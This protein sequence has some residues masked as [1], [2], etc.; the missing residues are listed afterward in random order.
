MDMRRVGE[1][2][3]HLLRAPQASKHSL[4]KQN[5]PINSGNQKRAVSLHITVSWK[6]TL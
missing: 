1:E 3:K 6:A 2:I 5:D 4:E